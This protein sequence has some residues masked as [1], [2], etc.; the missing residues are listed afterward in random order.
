MKHLSFLP[1]L[2]NH[3]LKDS[4]L[5]EKLKKKFSNPMLIEAIESRDK[6]KLILSIIESKNA[7]IN[8][9]QVQYL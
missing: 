9:K 6:L 1:D 5:Y 3:P 7:K 8:K 4:K 2:S